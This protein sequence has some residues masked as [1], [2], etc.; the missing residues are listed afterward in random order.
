MFYAVA[1]AMLTLVVLGIL[2]S[3]LSEG[4]LLMWNDVNDMM[5]FQSAANTGAQLQLHV[6]YVQV[7]LAASTRYGL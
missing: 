1:S 4:E 2:L 3:G 5:C 7:A 6:V